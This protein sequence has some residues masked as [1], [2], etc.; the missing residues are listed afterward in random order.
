MTTGNMTESPADFL[1]TLKQYEGRQVGEPFTGFDPV[2]RPMIRHWCD[3]MGDTLPVY[4]DEEAAAA[5][6]HGGII[7][8]PTMLQT[9]QMWG[10]RPRPATGGSLQDELLRRL[11]ANGFTSVV[12]T[13][14]EQEYLRELRPGDV[15][16]VTS[17]I[18]HVSEEKR[19]GLGVG[20]FVSTKQTYR[21]QDGEVVATMLFRILKFRPGTG[22]TAPAAAPRALR[23]RPALT[24]D[25]AWWFEAAR[26]HRLLIQRCTACGALRHPPGPM[27]PE[28]RSLAWDTI[29]ASGRGTVF[30]FVVNHYPQVAAFD[31]PLPIGLIELEE[32]TR[33]VANLVGTS[34]IRI[35]MP[36]TLVWEDHD[37]ALSLPAFKGS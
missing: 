24:K 12:A 2:N 6:V 28:C 33:L 3:A 8:P 1:A 27:C 17:T 23:P 9:W 18:E 4:T 25:N 29:E 11:D 22:R 36:V 10:F 13:N 32:G 15:V 7:A 21:D 16:T 31:Y 34:Q 5:S 37:D 35:G 30:S 19:T 20:H 14:C 26:E